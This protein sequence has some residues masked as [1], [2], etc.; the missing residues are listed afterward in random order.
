MVANSG[1]FAIIVV[2]YYF[3]QLSVGNARILNKIY[4]PKVA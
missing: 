4:W 2:L 1:I 3:V